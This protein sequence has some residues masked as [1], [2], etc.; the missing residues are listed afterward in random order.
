MGDY[1]YILVSNS[2]LTVTILSQFYYYIETRQLLCIIN[3]LTGFSMSVTLAWYGLIAK[4]CLVVKP[5]ENVHCVKSACIRCFYG[6]YFPP[7][8]LNMDQKNSRYGHF[9]RSDF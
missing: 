1:P 5:S 6:P 2:T 4:V 7:F 8:G 3:Q 9:S